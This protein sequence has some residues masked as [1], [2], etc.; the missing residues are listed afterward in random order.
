M[1]GDKI[2][3]DIQMS[4]ITSYTA[5]DFAANGTYGKGM[6]N[7]ACADFGKFDDVRTRK[8]IYGSIFRLGD[9]TI[10]P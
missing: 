9:A 6:F 7:F 4:Y 8:T 3:E 5:K 2:P 10:T 1:S